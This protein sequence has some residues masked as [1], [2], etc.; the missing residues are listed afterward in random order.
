LG[1]CRVSI[2][3]ASP[4]TRKSVVPERLLLHVLV[5]PGE[6]Q[7]EVRDVGLGRPDLLPVDPPAALDL[8]CRRGQRPEEVRAA[9]GLGHRDGE[10]ELAPCDPRKEFLLLLVGAEQAHGLAAGEGRQS[11]HPGQPGQRSGEL[12]GHDHLRDDVAALPAVFLRDPDTVQPGLAE[13]VPE[14]ER[15]LVLAGLELQRAFLGVVA[16]HPVPDTGTEQLLLFG[17]AEVHGCLR[18]G[19]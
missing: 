8:L 12:S 17:E 16:L 13:V 5:R 11:P 4:G 2:P 1:I 6:Q 15:V 10:L 18:P 19:C 3:G 7:D 9:T 14:L